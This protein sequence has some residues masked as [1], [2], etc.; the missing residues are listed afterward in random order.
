MSCKY[1]AA[2]ESECFWVSCA[3]CPSLASPRA[4]P[5][6]GQKN[7]CLLFWWPHDS[8]TILP[9]WLWGCLGS[10][11][12][13]E[14]MGSLTSPAGDWYWLLKTGQ[15]PSWKTPSASACGPVSY[16]AQPRQLTTLSGPYLEHH[17]LFR[18]FSNWRHSGT[19]VREHFR[20]SG[21]KLKAQ[22]NQI[23]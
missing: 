5:D 22:E 13:H 19:S 7:L 23:K 10:P 16:A 14:M 17:F 21:C 4:W 11:K 20:D 18:T 1:Q 12:D 2:L 3:P 9:E 6:Q 8:D 15:V